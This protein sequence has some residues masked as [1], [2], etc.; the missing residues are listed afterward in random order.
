PIV[1][2]RGTKAAVHYYRELAAEL[3][4][5]LATGMEAVP[6]ER[7]RIYWDGMPIWGQLRALSELFRGQQAALV[8]STY[9]NSWIFDFGAGDPW[10]SM[11]RSYLAI[12]ICRSESYKEQYITRRC[13]AFGASGVIFHD[14]KTCPH[15]TN[16]RFGLP[17][18]LKAATGLPVLTLEG[19]LN[20]PRCFSL[21]EARVRIEV[22]TE[23]LEEVSSPAG[24]ACC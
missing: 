4:V 7:H 2:L 19:D 22:F 13:R 3:T 16:S 8:A 15:N 9:C 24:K 20:D 17:Q 18:R 11:A 14:S 23:Q 12:F 1:V 5:R 6:Q 21:E 10:E